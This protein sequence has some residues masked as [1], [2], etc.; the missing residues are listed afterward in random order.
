M[1][2]Y[3]LSL[4]LGL[5]MSAAASGQ[6]MTLST[7]S[8]E[9]QLTNVFSNVDFFTIDIE[10]DAPL[11]SGVYINPV[12]IDVTYQ[13]QGTLEPDTPSGFPTFNLQRHM[14]GSEFYAQGSALSFE[15]DQ[16][17]VLD[18]GVQVSELVGLGVVL[19]F[20]AREV[21]TD[22]YHPPLLELRAIGT[23]RLQNSD[24]IPKLIP[25]ETVGFGEE[26]IT[27]LGFDPGNTTVIE[28]TP[29]RTFGGDSDCFIA[30]A[31][32]GSFM[33]PEVRLL[34]QF[35]DE[36]LLT[37][38]LGRRLVHL[39]YHYSPPVAAYIAE[40]NW[41]RL[42]SRV[43]LTPLV[44]SVKYPGA[45]LLIFIL[46]VIGAGSRFCGNKSAGNNGS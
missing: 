24:N 7:A 15:I 43:A 4:L 31:A 5:V 21:D 13:V 23:G 36:G 44:Y 35:R 41:L 1:R 30:T 39:Y 8:S 9:Y 22:R 26:Y 42:L 27:D 19:T 29:R 3:K 10:I 34:R 16:A 11:A 20:D 32:Y 17:A 37:N 25:L 33:E 28:E 18:D 38:K 40:R 6:T 12:I 2:L 46:M 45:A 14:T